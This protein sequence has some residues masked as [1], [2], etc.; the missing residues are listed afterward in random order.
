MNGL[1][2]LAWFKS[3]YSSANGQCVECVRLSDGG[4]A[5]RDS[6]DP[7]GAMLTYPSEVWRRFAD[8]QK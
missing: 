3:S 7:D 4:I 6:K 1:N 5:V 8:T 2:E